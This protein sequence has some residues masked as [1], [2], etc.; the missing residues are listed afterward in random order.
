MMTAPINA[1]VSSRPMTSS[2]RTYWVISTSP[3]FLT[4]A[5]GAGGVSLGR[6]VLFSAAQPSVAKTTAETTIPT[7]QPGARM[8]WFGVAS[9]RVSNTA[10]TMR[11]ATAPT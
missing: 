4:V 3:M 5:A 2:G 7:T 9:L 8:V 1:A 6:P 10:N 11:M